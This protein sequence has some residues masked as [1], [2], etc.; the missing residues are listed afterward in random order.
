M[1]VQFLSTISS[2]HGCARLD[3]WMGQDIPRNIFIKLAEQHCQNVHILLRE[4]NIHSY[5]SQSPECPHTSQITECPFTH[6]SESRMSKYISCLKP[7][8]QRCLRTNNEK[9]PHIT[10]LLP[11]WGLFRILESDV[12]LHYHGILI[13]LNSRRA[14]LTPDE[15]WNCWVIS[16]NAGFEFCFTTLFRV[17]RLR[18][19]KFFR[20]ATSFFCSSTSLA[21]QLHQSQ[22]ILTSVEYARFHELISY[23]GCIPL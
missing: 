23:K 8:E 2:T 21:F 15:L 6:I 11:V 17:L 14:T 3:V 10:L 13:F 5:I 9:H 20:S 1:P 7:H 19:R 4:Q 22:W 16:T 12:R 18:F